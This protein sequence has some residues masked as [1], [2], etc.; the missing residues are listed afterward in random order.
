MRRRSTLAPRL[1]HRASAFQAMLAALVCCLLLMGAVV[2]IPVL[3]WGIGGVAV[4][5]ALLFM[6]WHHRRH[7]HRA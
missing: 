6:A 2:L 4:V 5:A 3:G 7:G 1:P